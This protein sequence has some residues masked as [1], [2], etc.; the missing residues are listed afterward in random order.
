M[1]TLFSMRTTD[2]FRFNVLIV[3]Q[4]EQILKIIDDEEITIAP[5]FV[6]RCI[7]FLSI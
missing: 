4:Y 6:Y 7:N 1:R 5:L 3:I 2:A